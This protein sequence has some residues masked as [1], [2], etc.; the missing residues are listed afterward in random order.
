MKRQFSAR[1]LLFL[2]HSVYRAHLVQTTRERLNEATCS[3]QESAPSPDSWLFRTSAT[4]PN[5]RTWLLLNQWLPFLLHRG[6]INWRTRPSVVDPAFSTTCVPFSRK[7]LVVYLVTYQPG[8]TWS[9]GNEWISRMR[10]VSGLLRGTSS[11]TYFKRKKMWISC[12]SGG[13]ELYYTNLW[14]F[15]RF[16]NLSLATEAWRIYARRIL[17][18]QILWYKIRTLVR[19]RLLLILCIWY[20]TSWNFVSITRTIMIIL[21]KFEALKHKT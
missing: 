7:R 20:E 12:F 13:S 8:S 14:R 2:V 11:R 5:R 10:S 3:I 9:V 4:H 15:N 6:K 18:D 16:P 17:I 21:A 1:K 19:R